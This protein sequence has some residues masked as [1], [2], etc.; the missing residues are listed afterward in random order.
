MTAPDAVAVEATDVRFTAQLAVGRFL[1]RGSETT[2]TVAS[3]VALDAVNRPLT[4][5]GSEAYA[6]RKAALSRV[7][8]VPS[9]LSL[10]PAAARLPRALP[11]T[12]SVRFRL[13]LRISPV[14]VESP[15][16]RPAFLVSVL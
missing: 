10:T 3:L 16:S 14:T 4:E 11:A 5:V 8:L 2:L 6:P 15:M 7:K 1:F 13:I 12:E 9:L